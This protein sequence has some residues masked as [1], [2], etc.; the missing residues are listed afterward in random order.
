MPI[1]AARVAPLLEEAGLTV[2]L[3]ALVAVVPLIRERMN[4]LIEAPG[5]GALPVRRRGQVRRRGSRR[6]ERTGR[7][8]RRRPAHRVASGCTPSTSW[9]AEL[10]EPVVWGIGEELGPRAEAHGDSAASRDHRPDD[11]AAAVRVDGAAG[12]RAHAAPDRAGCRDRRL[13]GVPAVFFLAR[14][15]SGPVGYGVIGS[16][17]DSGS[18][19]LGSSPGTP[20]V[21]VK[22]STTSS[23]GRLVPLLDAQ[24]GPVV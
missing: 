1:S 17:A 10:I 8:L 5:P 14:A 7:G 19:S 24:L 23:N 11:L 15:P 3:G 20:A 12:S 16:P 21:T 9:S 4:Q 6:G 22:T 13:I 2:D 18:A